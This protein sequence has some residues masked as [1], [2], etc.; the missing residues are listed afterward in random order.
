S[1]QLETTDFQDD[2]RF[3]T[4]GFAEW[5]IIENLKFRTNLGA[6]FQY[7][8]RYGYVGSLANSNGQAQGTENNNLRAKYIIEN[9]LNYD[10]SLGKH[11]LNFLVGMAY[12]NEKFRFTDIAGTGYATDFIPT[13][14]AATILNLE[15][16]G[17]N[18]LQSTLLSYLGRLN[19]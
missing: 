7:R 11:D 6:Y 14:N 2:Y 9:T 4:S 5:D 1:G 13:L 12:E 8:N 16:T 10:V 15:D 3:V 19:Y 18:V 17:T